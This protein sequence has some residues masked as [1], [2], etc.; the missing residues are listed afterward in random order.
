MRAYLLAAA[1]REQVSILKHSRGAFAKLRDSG[2]SRASAG[3]ASGYDLTRI[4]VELSSL[5]ALIADV[6]R[7]LTKSQFDLGLMVGS[8]GT[9]LYATDDL[10]LQGLTAIA[11][12]QT[13][14]QDVAT[15]EAA[16]ARVSQH[17]LALDAA[18]SGWVPSLTLTGGVKTAPYSGDTA[19]GYV[20]GVALTLPIFGFGQAE[21]QISEAAL[22]RARGYLL[23]AEHQTKTRVA[24]AQESFNQSLQQATTF[25]RDQTPRLELL[26]RRAEV[27]YRE[28][29]RPVFE[30]LDAH[31]THR[32]VRLRS[33]RASRTSA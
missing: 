29:E 27:S 11:S 33:A 4:E 19:W 15:I 13:D 28:G 23:A 30:L 18:G 16:R 3:D 10:S 7:D 6:E 25:E 8:P 2:R 1:K 9:R 24:M 12:Y 20:T 21:K 31:R 22:R 26:L 5:D 32:E 14:K 17:S